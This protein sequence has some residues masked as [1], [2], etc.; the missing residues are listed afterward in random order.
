MPF[1]IA[2]SSDLTITPVSALAVVRLVWTGTLAAGHVWQVYANRRMIWYGSA[3]RCEL[4]WPTVATHYDLCSVEAAGAQT[5]FSASLPASP[6]RG[7]ASLCWY[8]GRYLDPLTHDVT[9]FRVYGESTPGGGISHATPLATVPAQ[10]GP[11][12]SDGFGRGR[13]DRGRF[14][15]AEVSFTWQ[16][17]PLPSSGTW[18]FA[19]TAAGSSGNES[20]VAVIAVNVTKPPNPPAPN[21]AGQ[22]LTY[23]FSTSTGQVTLNWNA[24]P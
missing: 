15:F 18:H 22:R 23:T 19:I 20:S 1:A 24:S 11:L 9:T 14:G 10:P 2:G 21:A 13:F 8:G 3:S 16:S 12:P 7:I 5:D 17:A 6:P 4:P